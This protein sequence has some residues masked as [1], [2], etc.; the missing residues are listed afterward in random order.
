[1]VLPFLVRWILPPASC[2]NPRATDRSGVSG[3]PAQQSLDEPI[4]NESQA[5]FHN[6]CHDIVSC[7]PPRAVG[8]AIVRKQP[9]GKV[10]KWCQHYGAPHRDHPV[11]QLQ[12][13][14]LH[15]QVS[16]CRTLNDAGSPE[17]AGKAGMQMSLENWSLNLP[18]QW[19]RSQSS[20]WPEWFLFWSSHGF[21][22]RND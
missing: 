4:C 8:S 20:S 14:W 19:E 12:A 16:M 1:M 7:S 6:A 17:P 9:W 11:I 2:Y 22:G 21:L 13:H 10:R 3:L 5:L 18:S 15:Q